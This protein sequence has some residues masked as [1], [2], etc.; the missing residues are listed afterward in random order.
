MKPYITGEQSA[1][2]TIS[3]KFALKCINSFV[4]DREVASAILVMVRANSKSFRIA[5]TYPSRRALIGLE[6]PF[7]CVG[8]TILCE[9]TKEQ[10]QMLDGIVRHQSNPV[11]RGECTICG[12]MIALIAKTG[13]LRRHTTLTET[14][15]RV[16][17]FGS[18]TKPYNDYK[19][20]WIDDMGT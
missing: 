6:L 9:P 12:Q 2:L 16:L 5:N 14:R 3:I 11:A 10:R 15:G 17:C 8:E 19:S 18:H 20:K 13:L 7:V 4:P 1:T